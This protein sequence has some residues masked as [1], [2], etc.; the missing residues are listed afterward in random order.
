MRVT[1]L[2]VHAQGI[3]KDDIQCLS[4]LLLIYGKT[5]LEMMFTVPWIYISIYLFMNKTM[6]RSF[7]NIFT[8]C[9]IIQNP[10]LKKTH[11]NLTLN[12]KIKSQKNHS[13]L[14]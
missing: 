13:F 9:F 2:G 1:S 11:K 12:A 3:V 7:Q 6:P 14:L 5:S 8:R 10:V 4:V